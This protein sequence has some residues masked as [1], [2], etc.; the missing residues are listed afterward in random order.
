ML[1]DEVMAVSNFEV[2][3]AEH[4]DFLGN[5]ILEKFQKNF[6]FCINAITENALTQTIFS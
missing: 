2:K 3:C 4:I 1:W 6:V 5:Y